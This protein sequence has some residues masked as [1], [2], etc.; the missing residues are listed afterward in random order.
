MQT[1]RD[2]ESELFSIVLKFERYRLILSFL[3]GAQGEP[4]AK[5]KCRSMMGTARVEAKSQTFAKPKEIV[6]S[7]RLSS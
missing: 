7:L 4:R 6:L 5:T 3:D 1:T 2:V